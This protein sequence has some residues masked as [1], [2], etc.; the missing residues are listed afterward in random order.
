MNAFISVQV[1]PEVCSTRSG[2]DLK[3][4]DMW[5][6]GVI[7]YVLVTGTVPFGGKN[8]EEIW[9]R[10]QSEEVDTRITFPKSLSA[11]CKQFI[12]GLVRRN[13]EDRMTATE[14]LQHPWI[15]GDAA[16]TEVISSCSYLQT[17]RQ[18][19]NRRNNLHNHVING[20][21][22]GIQPKDEETMHQN[23]LHLNRMKSSISVNEVED[24]FIFHSPLPVTP[25][26]AITPISG[27]SRE[28][29]SLFDFQSVSTSPMHL[30]ED[31][32]MRRI[33]E[34]R[35]RSILQVEP[36][37]DAEKV[38]GILKDKDGM[39]PLN[40]IREYRSSG[41]L[42]ST[43]SDDTRANVKEDNDEDIEWI[44]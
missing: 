39:I 22:K 33:T 3:K 43:R 8:Q 13:T 16:S 25:Q 20:I 34:E 9:Q 40:K 24:Y 28:S 29:H 4:G 2:E 37:Y 31:R 1:P 19:Q 14:A 7:C 30:L 17:L 32:L 35:F 42:F 36:E 5:S 11:S 26:S 21:L 12:S 6:I 44:D 18:C 23:L 10:I 41:N 27:Q 15:S 38:I